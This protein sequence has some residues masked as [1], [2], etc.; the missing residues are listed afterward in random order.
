MDLFDPRTTLARD[1]V[2]EQAL[3]GVMPAGSYRAVEPMRCRVSAAGVRKTRGPHGE[4]DNQLVFG[5]AFD[6]LERDGEWAFGRA[7]RD[8]HVGWVE[9]SA[10]AEGVTAPTHRVSAIRTYAFPEPDITSAP[11]MVLTL[12]S[13][14]AVEARQGRFAKVAGAGWVV[15]IHL[16]AFDTFDTDPVAVAE[17]HLG[18]PY[19]WGGRESIGLDCSGLVQ[20]SL[21]A[22]GRACP[23]DTDEQEH[24]TGEAI[25]PGKDRKGLRRGDLV[26]WDGHV[27][28]MVDEAQVIHANGHHL[29]VS[30][31][32]LADVV[33]RA[34]EPTSF[35]RL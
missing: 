23:R 14:V 24:E 25:D 10:L 2:A 5:E 19:Q 29:Q 30:I 35:R 4:L 26:F 27:A 15:E 6:V 20:Q 32:P 28:M 11:P 1:G 3:E 8:S 21:F 13:L 17:R 12:N 16:A 18:A 7:R 34:G 33:G 31:E 9:L 22:C